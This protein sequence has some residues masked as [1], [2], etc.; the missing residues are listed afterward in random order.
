VQSVIAQ[1]LPQ[2]KEIQTESM[3]VAKAD[4]QEIIPSTEPKQEEQKETE[5]SP[6]EK[7]EPENDASPTMSPPEN[8][9]AKEPK[10]ASE[11]VMKNIPLEE[12]DEDIAGDVKQ[13]KPPAKL[14]QLFIYE[15]RKSDLLRAINHVT[16]RTIQNISDTTKPTQA[17]INIMIAY[18]SILQNVEIERYPQAIQ[19]KNRLKFLSKTYKNCI[20]MLKNTEMIYQLTYELISYATSANKEILKKL[21]KI[22]GKYLA[23]WDM[24]P[25]AFS[26]KNYSARTILHVL[27]SFLAL[28]EVNNIKPLNLLFIGKNRL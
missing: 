14:K 7:F 26:D 24:K 13:D 19:H 21:L 10:I 27:T 22:R 6:E 15:Q 8:L 4:Q 12:L 5:L 11:P 23:G 2:N 3:H 1:E 16:V 18:L 9:T 20:E 28:V 25:S 17:V